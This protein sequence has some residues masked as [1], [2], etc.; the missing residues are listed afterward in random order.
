VGDEVH[1][2]GQ[3]PDPGVLELDRID[4]G[5]H[6][7][8]SLRLDHLPGSPLGRFRSVPRALKPG[9]GS[10]DDTCQGVRTSLPVLNR[11]ND[12][13]RIIELIAFRKGLG[14]AAQGL[15]LVRLV[16]DPAR[17]GQGLFQSRLAGLG[18]QDALQGGGAHIVFRE[19]R[20]AGQGL[21][22]A[23]LLN[24]G[25]HPR[26]RY[27]RP[28]PGIFLDP[29]C[30]RPRLLCFARL[31]QYVRQGDQGRHPGLRVLNRFDQG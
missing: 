28:F 11:S 9:K 20:R 12:R 17:G 1:Q 14:Q 15:R 5:Q 22:Q 23:L 8:Q 6:V 29:L 2:P 3:C 30:D 25:V 26:A 19:V 24:Q 7:I 18:V 4:P 21:V 13:E 31:Q 16:L 27:L 10:L